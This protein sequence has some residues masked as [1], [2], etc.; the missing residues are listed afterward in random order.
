MRRPVGVKWVLLFFRWT[1][2]FS[3]QVNHCRHSSI[4]TIDERS[5]SLGASWVFSFRPVLPPD[6]RPFRHLSMEVGQAI[7]AI[8]GTRL[9]AFAS[10]FLRIFCFYAAAGIALWL[11]LR[12]GSYTSPLARRILELITAAAFLV[13]ILYWSTTNTGR[14][15][16]IALA[17]GVA[18]RLS[19]G[20]KGPALRRGLAWC[21]THPRL[22]MSGSSE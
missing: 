10:S 1:R 21:P 18:A 7:N 9:W 4:R 6:Y 20:T 13:V 2:F 14:L 5:D 19:K 11:R 15:I 8:T 22:P 16:L 3:G 12:N 17:L